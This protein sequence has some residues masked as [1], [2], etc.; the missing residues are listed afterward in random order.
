MSEIFSQKNIL[1]LNWQC[2]ISGTT[3]THLWNSDEPLLSIYSFYNPKKFQR[4][5]VKMPFSSRLF[6]NI[7]KLSIPNLNLHKHE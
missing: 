7:N 3:S 1:F 2:F 6:I 4:M 5:D